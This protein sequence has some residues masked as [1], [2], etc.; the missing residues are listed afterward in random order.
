MSDPFKSTVNLHLPQVSKI[1]DPI[2]RE[3]MQDVL[4]AFRTIQLLLDEIK[5]ILGMP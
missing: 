5:T 3:E 4:A 1:A 2:T